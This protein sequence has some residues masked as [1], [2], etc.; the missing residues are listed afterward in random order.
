MNQKLPKG[1]VS[2]PNSG[3]N[4]AQELLFVK[5]L[6]LNLRLPYDYPTLNRQKKSEAVEFSIGFG[7]GS[8]N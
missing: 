8:T 6:T 3:F 7:S 4:I 2:P 1:L 5:N